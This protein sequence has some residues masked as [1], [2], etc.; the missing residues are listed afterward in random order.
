MCDRPLGT[1]A[2]NSAGRAS[3]AA[4]PV[5]FSF[6]APQKERTHAAE[7]SAEKTGKCTQGDRSQES[8]AQSRTP[9]GG[10][11][12]NR[13][14]QNRSSE[15]RRPQANKRAGPR[16]VRLPLGRKRQQRAG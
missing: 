11:A 9:E 4:C 2:K 3:S 6:E 14:A 12:Q 15:E 10:N 1:T 13:S 5:M 8:R 16:A 7:Q